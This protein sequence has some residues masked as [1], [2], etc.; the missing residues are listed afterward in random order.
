MRSPKA[1]SSPALRAS[2]SV[3]V[4]PAPGAAA[5]LASVSRTGQTLRLGGK[6][7]AADPG[8]VEPVPPTA[9]DDPHE[10]LPT[11][12]TAHHGTGCVHVDVDPAHGVDLAAP[13]ARGLR[14]GHLHGED[15]A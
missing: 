14:R 6:L 7:Q 13:G 8:Q 9:L 3:V 11:G 4:F 10:H 2:S 1:A 12:W 5:H 15:L